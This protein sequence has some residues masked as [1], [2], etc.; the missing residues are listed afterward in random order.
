MKQK[1]IVSK[2]K[3]PLAEVA[4]AESCTHPHLQF[5]RKGF[6]MRC[7]DCKRRFV[8]ALD[9]KGVEFDVADFTYWN[10]KIVDGEFRHSPHEAVRTTKIR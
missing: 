9:N 10:P 7:L 5:E 1:S 2:E 6:Q 4:Q 8:A 3:D